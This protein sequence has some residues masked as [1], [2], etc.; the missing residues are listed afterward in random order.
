MNI[1]NVVL[2]GIVSAIFTLISIQN[3]SSEKTNYKNC[4]VYIC[5]FVVFG[6][7]NVV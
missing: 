3:F 5:I 2:S 6:I 7:L 4:I 1:L